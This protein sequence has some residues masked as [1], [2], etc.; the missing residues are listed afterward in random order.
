MIRHFVHVRFGASVT[1]LERETV[2]AEL[3]QLQM[4]VPGVLD[5]QTRSNV[6]PEDVVV[7]GF[8]HLFWFD[9]DSAE[10][11][12]GYLVHPDHVIAGAKLVA[13]ADGG[14]DGIFVCDIEI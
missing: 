1:D 4:I 10:S 2:F 9:F 8:L 5:F 7:R 12:D 6:S 3:S 14:A 11:R 13:L